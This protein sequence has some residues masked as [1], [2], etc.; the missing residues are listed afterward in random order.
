MCE[1][2]MSIYVSCCNLVLKLSFIGI[3]K[4]KTEELNSPSLFANKKVVGLKVESNLKELKCHLF[5]YFHCL[6]FHVSVRVI[7]LKNH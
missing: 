2:Y 3:Q 4:K 6:K 7:I 1:W 5:L